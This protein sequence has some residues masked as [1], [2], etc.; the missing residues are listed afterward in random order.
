MIHYSRQ[1]PVDMCAVRWSFAQSL[2]RF[3]NWLN[4]PV[5]DVVN[6]PGERVKI[7]CYLEDLD[8]SNDVDLT[9]TV[10]N[11][12]SKAEITGLTAI[13]LI[14]TDLPGKLY[15]IILDLSLIAVNVLFSVQFDI[16]YPG[17]GLNETFKSSCFRI[18][19][20]ENENLIKIE[21]SNTVTNRFINGILFEEDLEYYRY[22][23]AKLYN[24]EITIVDN[25]QAADF[26][27]NKTLVEK[28]HQETD[29]FEIIDMPKKMFMG[30]IAI[31][32]ND[33]IYVN[34]RPANIEFEQTT[35]SRIGA[36]EIPFINALMRVTYS[37]DNGLLEI[38]SRFDDSYLL[39]KSDSILNVKS[40]EKLKIQ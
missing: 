31:S 30:L 16:D 9:V 36:Y 1:N 27:G 38:E 19:P 35:E 6:I 8:E 4:M 12:I 40:D 23:Y 22:L 11:E 28:T 33:I 37:D 39:V 34:G 2:D 15:E 14:P 18:Y 24:T 25:E 10:I 7:Q 13:T 5:Q 32:E 17:E 3:Y 29:I 20:G 26:Q 21:F